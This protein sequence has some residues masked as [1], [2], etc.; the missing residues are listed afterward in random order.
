MLSPFSHVLLFV[1]LLCPL[2]LSALL[3]GGHL[4]SGM[5]MACVLR[6]VRLGAWVELLT[7]ALCAH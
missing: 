5:M 1:T 6:Q 7:W 2:W 4:W 3:Q